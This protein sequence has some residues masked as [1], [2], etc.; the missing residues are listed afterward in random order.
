MRMDDTS[1]IPLGLIC[2][3]I[4]SSLGPRESLMQ[5]TFVEYELNLSWAWFLTIVCHVMF[6]DRLKTMAPRFF[7]FC[8]L[9]AAKTLM[10]RLYYFNLP[11]KYNG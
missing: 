2:I 3:G 6:E 4:A 10:I 5:I 11:F 7:F 1:L 9:A 8:F